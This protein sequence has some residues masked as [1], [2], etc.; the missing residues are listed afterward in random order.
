VIDYP[1]LA[2]PPPPGVDEPT[3]AAALLAAGLIVPVLDGL[4]EIPEAVRG[5]AI[6]RIN[7]ALRPGAQLVVT[8]RSQQYRDAVRPE[9][10]VEVTLRGAAAVE[11]RPLDAEAIHDYLCDDAAGPAARASVL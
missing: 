7:D 2:K 3:Q 4:D 10:G 1:A 5:P 8:C 6:S 11:L 9:D